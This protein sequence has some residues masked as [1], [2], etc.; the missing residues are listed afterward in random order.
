MKVRNKYLLIMIM[1]WGPCLLTAGA[2]Y[3]LVLRPQVECRQ[4]LEAD[5]ATCKEHYAR[6][7][8]AAKEKD[9]SRLAAEVEDLHNRIGDFV[10]SRADAPELAF[11]VGALANEQR[12]VAFGI[13]PTQRNG[14]ESSSSFERIAEKHVNLTFSGGFRSFA[15]FLNTLER[16]RPVLF[17]ETFTINRPMDRNAEPQVS[18]E[19]AVLVEEASGPAG[20]SR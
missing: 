15:A 13:R 16:H 11:N 12:L 8:E 3:A 4:E 5:V 20:A 2:A 14:T 19:L 7:V 10:M 17:V 6:A 1:A 18:M 9:Q